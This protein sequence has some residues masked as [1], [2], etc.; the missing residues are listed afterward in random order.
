MWVQYEKEFFSFSCTCT[1]YSFTGVV[2][3]ASHH[4]GTTSLLEMFQNLVEDVGQVLAGPAVED[5]AGHTA[6][7]VQNQ[8][9]LHTAY[10]ILRP[11][12]AARLVLHLQNNLI[13]YILKTKPL[14]M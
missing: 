7:L 6:V 5:P 13:A 1:K 14:I 9:H 3:I 8:A 10:P 2:H 11:D 12:K 4:D